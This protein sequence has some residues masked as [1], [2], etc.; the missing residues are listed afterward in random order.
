MLIICQWLV[1]SPSLAA[2]LREHQTPSYPEHGSPRHYTRLHFIL[3]CVYHSYRMATLKIHTHTDS[4]DEFFGFL[5]TRPVV[6]FRPHRERLPGRTSSLLVERDRCRLI[7]F[8]T[9]TH[10]IAL[11]A[12]CTHWTRLRSNN[13]YSHIIIII[14]QWKSGAGYKEKRI[15]IKIN[16]II[17]TTIIIIIHSMFETTAR[18]PTAKGL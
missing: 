5:G 16:F 11:T 2:I 7:R 8:G 9:E 17:V 12:A 15:I 6:F 10:R 14:F 13:Y 1:T 4:W 18:Y 3:E